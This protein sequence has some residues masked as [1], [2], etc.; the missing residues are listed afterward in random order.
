MNRTIGL[1]RKFQQ[2]LPRPSFTKLTP[3]HQRLESI[4]YNATLVII[5][6]I[7][8][9]SKEKLCQERRFESLQSRRWFRKLSLLQNNKKRIT[10]I[11]LSSNSKTINLIFY[12]WLNS[13]NLLVVK[14]NHSFFKNSFSI[15]H[16]RIELIRFEYSLLSF[17]KAFHK[18]NA[19]LYDLSVMVFLM[20]LTL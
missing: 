6:T 19:I 1:L 8:R 4:Q 17:L 3:S 13:E 12:L 7:R 16:H 2:V 14:A 9:T 15:Y 5:R 11:S 18:M 10:I 20:S